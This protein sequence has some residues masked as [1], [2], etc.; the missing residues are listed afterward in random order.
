VILVDGE[1]FAAIADA[2][3]VML[4]AN[5]GSWSAGE[6]YGSNKTLIE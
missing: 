2:E 5:H 3:L 4:L 1:D 6:R